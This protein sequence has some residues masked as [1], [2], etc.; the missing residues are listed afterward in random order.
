[1]HNRSVESNHT[2][3][4]KSSVRAVCYSHEVYKKQQFKEVEVKIFGRDMLWH[5]E[6]NQ[7]YFWDNNC[8]KKI[9]KNLHRNKDYRA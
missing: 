5:E 4:L 9:G 1:M 3:Y 7:A 8:L 6:I 2:F